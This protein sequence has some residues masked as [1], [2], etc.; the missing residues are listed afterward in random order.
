[1]WWLDTNISGLKLEAAVLSEMLVSIHHTMQHSSENRNSIFT[2]LKTSNSTRVEK[3]IPLEYAHFSNVFF[4]I[5]HT[6][7]A[8][9]LL[10]CHR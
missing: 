5:L 9:I 2:T 6:S 3:C 1:V 7:L 4:A 8:L 10:V